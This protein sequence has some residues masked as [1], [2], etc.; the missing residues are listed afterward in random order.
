MPGSIGTLGLLL[1]S[2]ILSSLFCL[3]SYHNY[4]GGVALQR[5]LHS[6]IPRAVAN[7]RSSDTDT[8][9]SRRRLDQ[10]RRLVYKIHIDVPAAM[11]GVSRSVAPELSLDCARPPSLLPSLGRLLDLCDYP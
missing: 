2:V 7:Q 5:L 4:P 9:S 3:A 6:H 1:L 8:D 10:G 11:S